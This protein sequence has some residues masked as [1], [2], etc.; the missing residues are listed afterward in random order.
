MKALIIGANGQLGRSLAASAP[1]GFEIVSHNRL[2]LD[3]TDVSA[4]DRTIRDA[5]ADIVLNAAAYTAVDRAEEEVD[6]AFAVNAAAVGIMADAVRNTGGRFVHV[7]TDFIFDGE[8]SRPYT[9]DAVPNPLSAYG[10]SKLAGESQ[11]GSDTLIFRTSWV[12]APHSTN[13]VLTM[14][15]LMRTRNRLGV[16]ADQIGTPTYAQ[17]LAAAIWALAVGGHVGTY[18]YSDS[19][20]ASWYDF[21]FAIQEEALAIGLLDKAIPVEPVATSDYPTAARRPHYSVLDKSL[22]IAALGRTPPHWRVNLRKMLKEIR[23]NG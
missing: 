22:T 10:R 15:R 2:T 19:G 9:I 4:V 18:H 14:L 13:F 3:I 11:A 23:D 12:Y 7:S 6:L 16:I 21:A 5:E 20:V 17:D 8:S 1:Q